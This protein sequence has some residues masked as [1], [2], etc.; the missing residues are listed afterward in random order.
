[1]SDPI[2]LRAI[3]DL[4]DTVT[5]GQNATLARLITL[6]TLLVPPGQRSLPARV[7]SLEK[8]N[9]RATGALSLVTLAFTGALHWLSGKS[10]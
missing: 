1:M 4:R 9:Y 3:T 8:W 7:E 2:I 6:E 10:H 5:I